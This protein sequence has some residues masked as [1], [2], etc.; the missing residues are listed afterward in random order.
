VFFTDNIPKRKCKFNSELKKK[1]LAS[2]LEE[3][4]QS[5]VYYMQNF[6]VCSRQGSYDLEAHSNT[7]KYKKQIQS[8]H[9][10]LDVSEFFIK[11]NLK[12][13]ER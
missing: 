10:T 11:Q 9:N 6:H 13:E 8:C 3:M 5:R 12:T 4:N 7:A 2:K 1:V